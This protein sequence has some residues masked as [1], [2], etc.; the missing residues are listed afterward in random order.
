MTLKGRKFGKLT[1]SRFNGLID[2]DEALN[3]VYPITDVLTGVLRIHEAPSGLSVHRMIAIYADGTEWEHKPSVTVSFDLDNL[4]LTR[5]G[6]KGPPR[7]TVE[8]FIAEYALK[9]QDRHVLDVLGYLSLGRPDFYTLYKIY[10][11]IAADLS[12]KGRDKIR[13]AAW[14]PRKQFDEFLSTANESH[15]HWNI[16]KPPPRMRLAEARQIMGRIIYGWIGDKAG[17]R[18]PPNTMGVTFPWM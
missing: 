13:K 9:S 1:S 5:L 11:V 4:T 3:M 8:Q 2:V 15:R 7:L 16:N 17:V 12:P 18:I 14:V 6:R 10:E